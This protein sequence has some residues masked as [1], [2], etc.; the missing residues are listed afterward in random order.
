[1][2][3]G[4]MDA[5]MTFEIADTIEHGFLT[6][7][8]PGLRIIS[9]NRAET[10]V[11]LDLIASG[12]SKCCSC[13]RFAGARDEEASIGGLDGLFPIVLTGGAVHGL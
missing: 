8:N 5:S 13:H 12:E 9:P 3:T 6:L 1:M 10:R 7:Q 2:L 4:N 11:E